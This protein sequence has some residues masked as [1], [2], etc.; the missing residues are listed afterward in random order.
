VLAWAV[1]VAVVLREV[2]K[3]VVAELTELGFPP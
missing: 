2:L 3:Q 1:Q